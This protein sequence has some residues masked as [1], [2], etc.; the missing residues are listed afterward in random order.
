MSEVAERMAIQRARA[1]S[2]CWL[3]RIVP[4]KRLDLF[5]EGSALAIREGIDLRLTI[6]GGIGFIPGYEKMIEA[7]PFRDRLTWKRVDSAT[8]SALA[9]ARS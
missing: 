1:L 6:V 2:I 8:G 9:A 7:F 5:L 4:R 3:G